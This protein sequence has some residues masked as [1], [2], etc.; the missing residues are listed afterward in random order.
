MNPV[1]ILSSFLASSVE[2]AEAFTI[3]LA[4]FAVHGARPALRGTL[5]ALAALAAIAVVF[6]PVLSHL[7]LAWLR[8]GVGT[9]ILLMGLKWLRKAILRAAGRKALHDEEEA[10]A[11]TVAEL[12]AAK[13]SGWIQAAPA[14]N[15]VLLEGLEVIVIVS[16]LGAS[17]AAFPSAI[18]GGVLGAV[19]VGG[20]GLS[21]HRPLSQVPENT[22]KFAVGLLLVGLGT[23]WAG[24]GVGV[25][26][27][28][29]DTALA[30]LLALYLAVALW[31]VRR[32]RG[33]GSK[34]M[35]GP[36]DAH[37]AA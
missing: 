33:A 28:G 3:V 21:L 13:G 26:W 34:R 36:R 15:G 20:L 25:R 4:V 17:S 9:L 24:E 29:G 10:Y 32:L 18:V 35:G 16:T 37:R 1:V 8:V 30:W 22:L 12:K 2:M 27:P 19:V 14:F 7:P 31:Q 11:K 5:W 23:L 6:G